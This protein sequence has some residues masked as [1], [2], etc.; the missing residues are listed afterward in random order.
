M[1]SFTTVAFKTEDRDVDKGYECRCCQTKAFFTEDDDGKVLEKRVPD[2]C[3]V[4]G[5]TPLAW[6]SNAGTLG[7]SRYSLGLV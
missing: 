4:T 3:D 6:V 2:P 5:K 7:G 1:A